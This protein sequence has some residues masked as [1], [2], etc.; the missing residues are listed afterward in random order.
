VEFEVYPKLNHFFIEGE[1]VSSGAEHLKPG[2]VS[3]AVVED[4]AKWIARQ[5]K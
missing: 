1:G 3:A 4:I 2:H 5:A